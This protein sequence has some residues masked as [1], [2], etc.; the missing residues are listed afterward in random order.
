MLTESASFDFTPPP[1]DICNQA[2][3]Q[4][5][6]AKMINGQSMSKSGSF[7]TNVNSRG[8]VLSRKTSVGDMVDCYRN[9]LRPNYFSAKQRAGRYKNKVSGYANI[10]VVQDP[11]FVVSEASRQRVLKSTRNV[12][13]FV[14][15]KFFA[16]FEGQLTN[17]HNV[18]L[19][20][21][22][23]SPYLGPT[24]FRRDNRLPITRNDYR[25]FA[26]L[27]GSDVFLTDL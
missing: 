10:L 15:G 18:P 27:S 25:R 23:Y 21:V 7:L 4:D 3:H 20:A 8:Q 24:F 16:A 19:L 22:S 13:A 2:S 12:H 11:V 6:L 1:E 5:V 9:L 26:I 17:D 14:R